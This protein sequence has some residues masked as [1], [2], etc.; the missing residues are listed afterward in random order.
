MKEL[1]K[2]GAGA[3]KS[4]SRILND[5][6]SSRYDIAVRNNFDLCLFQLRKNYVYL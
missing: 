2:S 6:G 1:T 5:S 3:A 4:N